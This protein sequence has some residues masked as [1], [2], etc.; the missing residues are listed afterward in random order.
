M[1]IKKST[2]AFMMLGL[3]MMLSD[4][5]SKRYESY[6]EYKENPNRKPKEI[7]PPI[8]KNCK[9]YFFTKSGHFFNSIPTGSYAI[10]YDCVALNDKNAIK[11][12]NNWKLKQ[13]KL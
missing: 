1:G 2:S 12:F 8:P 5:G 3:G 11:K 13:S 4:Y 10:V 6:E 7:E 9:K